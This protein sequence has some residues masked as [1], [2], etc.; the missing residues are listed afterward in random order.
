MSD[1][2]IIVRAQEANIVVKTYSKDVKSF[3][4]DAEK[5]LSNIRNNVSAMGNHWRGDIYDSYKRNMD[6]QLNQMKNCIDG[7]SSLSDKL[8]VISAKFAEAIET[9]KRSAGNK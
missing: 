5:E 4:E 1:N 2:S 8:D 6:Q 7:L 9:I 3:K